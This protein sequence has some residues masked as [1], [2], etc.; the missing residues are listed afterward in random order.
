MRRISIGCW[1]SYAGRVKLVAITGASNVTGFMPDIHR[2]AQKAHAAGAQDPGGLPRNW[3]RIGAS[4]MGA[5]DDPAHLDYVALSAHKMYAPFGTGALIGRRDTFEQ[6]SRNT[7]A[8][9]RSR[10]SRID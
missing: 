5:L 6:A 3:R 2:L 9:A 8:A 4:T 7:A 10:S 1:R